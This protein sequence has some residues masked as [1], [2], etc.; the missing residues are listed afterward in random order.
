MDELQKVA[1]AIHEGYATKGT[2]PADDA[3]AWVA[4]RERGYINC[5]LTVLAEGNSKSVVIERRKPL[6]SLVTLSQ[7]KQDLAE[8]ASKLRFPY[9]SLSAD[10]VIKGLEQSVGLASW[11][12]FQRRRGLRSVVVNEPGPPEAV[13]FLMQRIGWRHGLRITLHKAAK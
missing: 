7:G 4:A 10:L 12:P 11:N 8:W 3:E 1:D 2:A 6:P 9:E 13:I 5:L